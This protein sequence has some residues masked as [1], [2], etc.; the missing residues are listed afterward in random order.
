MKL[1]LPIILLSTAVLGACSEKA[2]VPEPTKNIEETDDRTPES[3]PVDIRAIALDED[4]RQAMERVVTECE[5]RASGFVCQN[6]ENRILYSGYFGH[7]DMVK[8]KQAVLGTIAVALASKSKKDQTLAANILHRKYR[9]YWG[10]GANKLDPLVPKL[11]RETWKNLERVP[12]HRTLRTVVEASLVAKQ[13]EELSIFLNSLTSPSDTLRGWSATFFNRRM[14]HLDRVIEDAKAVDGGTRIVA[15]FLV[16]AAPLQEGETERV[17]PWAREQYT[18][19]EKS[20]DKALVH[21][22][23]TA[24]AGLMAYCGKAGNETLIKDLKSAVEKKSLG[25]RPA[26][27]YTDLCTIPDAQLLMKYD[28]TVDDCNEIVRLLGTLAEDL[29]AGDEMRIRATEALVAMHRNNDEYR[30]LLSSL[31]KAKVEAVKNAALAG[32]RT[33]EKSKQDTNAN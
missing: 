18:S 26:E 20:Q 7:G 31:A 19:V 10:I 22:E 15:E 9:G 17:C 11:L 24:L 16:S 28:T 30:K 4:V 27:L 8:D 12:R 14:K 23:Y 25:K 21:R 5:L 29:A 3:A 2:P 32:P 13:D 1:L 6:N 33:L